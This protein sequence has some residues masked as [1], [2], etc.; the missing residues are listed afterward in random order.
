MQATSQGAWGI[1]VDSDEYLTTFQDGN[2]PGAEYIL[3]SAMKHLDVAVYDTIEKYLFGGY[4]AGE[5]H[6][7]LAA[8]GVGLAPYHAADPFVSQAVRD[9]LALVEAG[10][11]DGTIDVK[12]AC[13]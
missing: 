13:P 4:S 9:Y 5:A 8:G 10:I 2:V 6:Y 3:S 1:G 11:I 12:Q 7:D